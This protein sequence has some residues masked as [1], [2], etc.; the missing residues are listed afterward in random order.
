MSA[1]RGPVAAGW[2]D[3]IEKK[4]A[5]ALER[6]LQEGALDVNECATLQLPPWTWLRL[7]TPVCWAIV[8]HNTDALA[9]LLQQDGVD[10]ELG[11]ADEW[12]VDK[13]TPLGLAADCDDATAVSLLLRAGASAHRTF[14][15]F[16]KRWTAESYAQ[17]FGKTSTS[18]ALRDHRERA[19]VVAA[20]VAAAAAV[21]SDAVV[22]VPAATEAPFD[23]VP[24]AETSVVVA[25]VPADAP[26]AAAVDVTVEAAAP[27]EPQSNDTV[28]EAESE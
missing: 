17:A 21:T 11:C 25:D 20:D 27:P 10:V 19:A 26:Q 7:F 16:D 24:S 23:A 8:H 3:A 1:P 15:V 4:D 5:I 18:Q 2:A 12:H 14:R 9:L 28:P 6:M 13:L 22:A